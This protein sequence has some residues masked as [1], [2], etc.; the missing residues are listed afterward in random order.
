MRRAGS[1]TD[2]SGK[3]CEG[4]RTD[5]CAMHA[6]NGGESKAHPRSSRSSTIAAEALMSHAPQPRPS[7]AVNDIELIQRGEG[8]FTEGRWRKQPTAEILALNTHI[9]R[10]PSV[11]P[12][13]E[14]GP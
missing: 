3:F 5:K 12:C 2:R 10:H 8:L 9:K 11:E 7:R 6:W 14:L 13:G 4:T 1:H